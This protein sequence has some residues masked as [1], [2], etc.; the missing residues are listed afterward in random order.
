MVAAEDSAAAR[1]LTAQLLRIL[2][3]KNMRVACHSAP[4]LLV[5]SEFLEKIYE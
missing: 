4:L 3:K 1:A 2:V 5:R